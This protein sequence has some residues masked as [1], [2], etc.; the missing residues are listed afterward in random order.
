M[1]RVFV[2]DKKKQPLMPCTPA[3]SRK[4]LSQQKAAV[5][6][7]SSRHT[8]SWLSIAA[9]KRWLPIQQSLW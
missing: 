5:Y 1:Q 6:R 7:H 4:L 2:L 9:T 8:L 3:R